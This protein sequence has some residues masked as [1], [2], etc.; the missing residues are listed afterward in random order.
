[1]FCPPPL[2]AGPLDL[3]GVDLVRDLVSLVDTLDDD[4]G[5]VRVVIID[6][7]SPDYFSAHVDLTA[8]PQYTAEPAKAGGPGDASLGMFL[9]K[10]SR[11]RDHH[12]QGAQPCPRRRQRT[13]A[14]LRHDLR[15]A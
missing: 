9:H 5:N 11:V 1:M 13:R 15:V 4:P 6:S 14:G 8:V 7:P 2:D 12:R 10:L 3:L